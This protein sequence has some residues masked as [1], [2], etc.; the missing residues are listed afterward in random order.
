MSGAG[1]L[2]NGRHLGGRRRPT[3]PPLFHLERY[4]V[5]RAKL[6]AP[7]ASTNFAAAAAKILGT[8]WANGPSNASPPSDVT[9]G[10]CT[11]E[12]KFHLHA[13]RQGAAGAPQFFASAVQ[14]LDRYSADTG[15]VHGDTATDQ[16][17]DDTIVLGNLVKNPLP[18]GSE[19][20]AW[21][22]IDGTDALQVRSFCSEFVGLDMCLEVPDAL[23]SA[24]PAGAGPGWGSPVA[25]WGVGTPNPN[26]GHCVAGVDQN[27]TGI[28]IDT[29]GMPVLW[30]YDGI[31]ALANP[32]AGGAVYAMVSLDC[33][34]AAIQKAPD[35]LDYRALVTDWDAQGGTVAMPPSGPAALTLLERLEAALGRI[36]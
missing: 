13:L 23:M 30:T 11:I 29:W 36:L 26:S 33:L 27:E 12:S 16:G 21:L 24:V 17:A 18:D 35:G 10:D 7:P 22:A 28:T 4:S 20:V 5:N 32:T 34:V 8:C 25:T 6:A 3:T 19:I 14:V 2:V 9:V 1:Q 31:A 15:Y